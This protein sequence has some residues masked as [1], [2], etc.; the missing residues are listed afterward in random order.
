MP[1]VEH[2]TTASMS[3]TTEKLS[4]EEKQLKEKAELEKEAV[5]N[6]LI[7]GKSAPELKPGKERREDTDGS[8]FNIFIF[9][10]FF[11]WLECV[12]HYFAY[13]AH[14]V[15]FERCLDSNPESCRTN[16]ATHLALLNFPPFFKQ[17]FVACHKFYRFSR[18]SI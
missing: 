12:G 1:H 11:L 5:K 9:I 18:S 10:I 17:L 7:F 14:V 6:K 2:V 8:A 3:K 16:L 15:S 4:P 13:V